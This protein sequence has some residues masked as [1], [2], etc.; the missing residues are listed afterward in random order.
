MA[1]NVTTLVGGVFI[2]EL[3]LNEIQRFREDNL[4]AAKRFK[5]VSGLGEIKKMGDVLHVPKLTAYTAVDKTA[6]TELP[7]SATTESEVTLTVNKHKGVRIAV[8]GIA[9]AQSKYDLMREYTFAEGYA[10]AIALDGD[11]LSLYSGLSQTVG[12]T[13]STDGG[14]SDTLIV[15]AVQKLNRAKAPMMDR[16][17]IIDSFGLADLQL[18]EKF[19]RYDSTGQAGA[20]AV[21]DGKMGSIY[22]INVFVTENV[23]STSV[24]GGTLSCGLIC[25]KDAFMFASQMGPKIETW[26]NAPQLTDELIAQQ[27]YGVAEYR[28][29]HGVVLSYPQN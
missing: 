18:L 15:S 19:T 2:P 20:N 27:L 11:L 9:A 21:V 24:V 1:T 6:N 8:E 12:A 25:H 28:D 16:S 29:D 7:A 4:V 22:G 3:W 13:A 5:D 14:I 10:L 17:I 26:R 23:Q